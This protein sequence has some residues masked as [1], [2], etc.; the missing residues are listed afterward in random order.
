MGI[1]GRSTNDRLRTIWSSEMDQYFIT[2]MLEQVNKGNKIDNLFSKWAW[3]DMIS[4][5][6]E[7]FKFQYEKDILKNRHKVLRNLYSAVKK[8]LDQ[9]GF[10][11]DD[12]RQMVTADNK[13]WDAYLKVYPDVRSFRIKTIPY[14]NDLCVIYKKA[15]SSGKSNPSDQNAEVGG[16]FTVS[17]SV[18]SFEGL[19]SPDEHSSNSGKNTNS[20]ITPTLSASNDNTIGKDNVDSISKSSN[21]TDLKIVHSRTIWQP[22]MD[23]FFISLMVDHVQKGNQS[24]GLFPKQVWME[25]ANIFNSKFGFKYDIEILKNRFKTLRRQHKL[26]KN[27]LDLDG[28]SWDEARQMVAAD[29]SIWQDYI[30]THPTARQYM[31]RPVPYY[32]DLCI[33]CRDTTGNR[34]DNHS[35]INLCPEDNAQ[36]GKS[37]S[38]LRDTQSPEPSDSSEDLV[39]DVRVFGQ[40]DKRD[41]ENSYVKRARSSD[42]MG[43]SSFSVEKV[44]EAIQVLPEMDEDL[45]LD[46]CDFLEDEKKAKMFLALDFK[47]RKKWLLR[48]LRPQ[49]A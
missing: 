22:P 16:N 18:T 36:G 3:M 4:A 46:A 45:I 28:F 39:E 20:P 38:P 21:N 7:K 9:K 8:I 47:L 48:K 33:I 44:V 15:I 25:M 5:F 37:I 26:I 29:D 17:E 42:D 12:D 1:R 27:L 31:A 30:K 2:L 43:S 40:K 34:T 13:V 23:H 11:W 41:L 35:T 24:D 6:N 19:E 10:S 49:W 32:K 14:Y